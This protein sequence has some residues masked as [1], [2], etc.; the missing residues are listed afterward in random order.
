MHLSDL[1]NNLVLDE[2][3]LPCGRCLSPLLGSTRVPFQELVVYATQCES[4]VVSW[5]TGSFSD[6]Q[7]N[8]ANPVRLV[9]VLIGALRSKA[10]QREM[11][12]V[13][14]SGS[15]SQLGQAGASTDD[16]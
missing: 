5:K 10:V 8:L 4:L 7:P 11:H 6:L 15:V 1:P 12:L 14:V 16:T 2:A 13:G 9:I 3:F